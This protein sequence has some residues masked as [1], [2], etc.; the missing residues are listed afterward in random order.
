MGNFRRIPGMVMGLL[1]STMAAGTYPGEWH[2]QLSRNGKGEELRSWQVPKLEGRGS[3]T[4]SY[5]L[6]T[7]EARG[8]RIGGTHDGCYASLPHN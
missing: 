1:P 2:R 3:S 7:S 8:E 4:K 6:P 5:P